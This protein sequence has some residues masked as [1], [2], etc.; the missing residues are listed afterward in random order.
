MCLFNANCL[1]HGA[2]TLCRETHSGFFHIN[3]LPHPP[4]PFPE[5]RG[6]FLILFCREASPPAPRVR[7]E[8]LANSHKICSNCFC[9][10]WCNF[11]LCGQLQNLQNF[12]QQVH[13]K[14]RRSQGVGVW[15]QK[16]RRMRWFCPHIRWRAP[17]TLYPGRLCVGQGDG[18]KKIGRE[19]YNGDASNNRLFVGK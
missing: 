10:T 8:Y 18:K 6:K 15:G 4:A 12:I 3:R 19:T 13:V 16:L 11:T 5:G 7:V 9:I 17:Y 14:F 2:V 1:F